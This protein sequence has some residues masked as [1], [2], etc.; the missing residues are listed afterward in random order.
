VGSKKAVSMAIRNNH[1]VFRRTTLKDRL[2]GRL[3]A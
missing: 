2:K 1:V 3:P